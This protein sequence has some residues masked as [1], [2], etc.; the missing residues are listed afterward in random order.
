MDVVK[1]KWWARSLSA[2][3]RADATEAIGNWIEK[4]YNRRRHSALGQIGP[5]QFE[6]Q[7]AH[8]G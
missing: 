1:I 4:V 2:P 3:I 6:L 5:I 7:H 8:R